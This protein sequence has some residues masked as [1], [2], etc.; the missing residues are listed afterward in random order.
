MASRYVLK[1]DLKTNSKQMNY[2]ELP[3][4]SYAYMNTFTYYL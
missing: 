2:A 1:F 3:H 4:M